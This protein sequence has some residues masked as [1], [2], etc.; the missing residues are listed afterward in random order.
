LNPVNQAVVVE[1]ILD[2]STS[3][4]RHNIG[5]GFSVETSRQAFKTTASTGHNFTDTMVKILPATLSG[6]GIHN[7]IYVH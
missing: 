7:I 2:R 4:F 6:S 1:A 3:Q 5:V